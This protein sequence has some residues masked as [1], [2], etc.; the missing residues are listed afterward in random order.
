MRAVFWI[1]CFTFISLHSMEQSI[2]SLKKADDSFFKELRMQLHEDPKAR[3]IIKTCGGILTVVG[4]FRPMTAIST[5]TV[6]GLASLLVYWQDR[7]AAIQERKQKKDTLALA[8]FANGPKALIERVC[9]ADEY[10]Q[11]DT[12]S[13]QQQNTIYLIEVLENYTHD[14]HNDHYA[15]A[16]NML[17]KHH[18]DFYIAQ[19]YFKNTKNQKALEWLAHNSNSTC[20]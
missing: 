8:A 9:Q 1:V 10:K 11:T 16:L 3:L 18:A 20:A 13:L 5:A 17:K 2:I 12:A 19:E 7:Q 4:F 14:L 6:A 15:Y